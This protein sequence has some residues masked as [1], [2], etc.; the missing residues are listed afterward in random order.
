MRAYWWLALSVVGAVLL[1][2]LVPNPG[3]SPD[4][5]VLSLLPWSIELLPEGKSKV[6]GVILGESKLADLQQVLGDD[7]ELAI[8]AAPGEEGSLEAYFPQLMLG[9]VQ[10]RMIVTVDVPET[11]I[12]GMRE[13][14]SKAEY[15]EGATRKIRLHPDDLLRV[16]DFP[17]RAIA[18]I[19][20]ANLDEAVL[21][22]RFGVPGERIQVSPERLHL[23]YP[24]KG[25]DV[26][27]DREAKELLQYVPPRNFSMLRDPLLLAADPTV[28]K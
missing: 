27:L 7:L 1:S 16:R 23:L 6:F 10:A 3:K 25:L 13:R 4:A 15:M 5:R 18:V 2:L 12:S 22:E 26:L 21:L 20:M 19:P 28:T 9:F 14:A 24:E 17:I 8:V 11:Q